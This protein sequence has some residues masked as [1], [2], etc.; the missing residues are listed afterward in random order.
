[1]RSQNERQ[2]ENPFR[3]IVGITSEDAVSFVGCLILEALD[4]SA[5]RTGC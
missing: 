1:M 4:L 2:E 5:S 3:E